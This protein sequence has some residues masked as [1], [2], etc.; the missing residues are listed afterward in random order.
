MEQM[1]KKLKL[2]TISEL[3]K[4]IYCS[5]S[6]LIIGC[7]S[8]Y[9]V[10]FNK[11]LIEA[12]DRENV[13]LSQFETDGQL[14]VGKYS[15]NAL[16]NN[17]RTPIHLDL[18]WVLID[19][20]TA[21]CLTPEQLTLLGFTDEIIEVAQQNLID[22]CYPIEKEKQITTY[23]DKG[24]M[25]LS[26]SAPQ[27]WLKYKDA[28]WTP[29][30]LWDH[31]IAGAFL[32]YNLYASHYA[33]HQ[34]DNSQNISSYGQAGVNLGAWRLRTDYQYDQSF[35]NGKS[36]ANNLDFPRIYLFRPIPEI[37]AKLTIGQYDT[38]SSIFDS[39]HFSG[40]SLKSDE[41][42]LPPDLRG[43][44]PQITGVAQTN[45]KVTVSQNNRII[46]QENV[47][48]GPFA[49][50]NLFN[51]LQGQLDVKV[52]EEDGQVTQWQVASNSIPY[53]TRKGQ[54]RYTTAMGKP[55]S[56]GGDSL[57]QPFF[58]TGEF[59]WG[60]LNN[61]SLYGGSVLTNRDYQSL[62]AGV[63]FN[64]NSLGSLSFDVTRSDAQLHNQDKETGYSY[65]A[66]Y[67]KRFESTGSQLTFAGYRFSDKNFVT[68]NEY[69]NDTN[70]Y[71]NYQNE[72]ESYIV[73]FNQ[74]LESLRLNTYV[75]LA[76]NTY[77][78]ASSNVNYSLSLSRDFDIGPLKNVSTSLT[79]SRINWEED[80]QDQLYL[81]ISIPWGT[82]RTLSYGMQRNQDNKI[83][84]TASW[85]DSSDRNNSWSVSASGD[86]DEFKDMKASLR[87]SYQHNTENGRL[88]LSGTS[89]RDS[90]YSLNASW[91]GSFT[92]TRHGAAFHDYSGSADSRFMIDADG[93]EDIP[94]NNKRAVTN[95][96]G[97]GVIPSV[98]SYIT[99]SLSV[100]TRNLPENVDIENSVITTTLT[101]G[102]IGYAKLDTRKGYQI[103]GV[104]R[105]AD[106]SHPPLGI[107]VKDKTSHKE[108]GLVADGGFV[109]LNGIQD[110]SKLTLRWGDKS[111]FIQPPNSSNLTTGTVIL[112][113]IS[114]N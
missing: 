30:E 19:N 55:T 49:I 9:A 10:E 75:S 94:L 96:Y 108:L 14:P 3:I 56:V 42:M 25:Q 89:Q 11:D 1:Y 105:L 7:A 12:E 81:N 85:Y 109:Y 26:I 95:R 100:D 98:S 86:N 90:Y 82:S 70:H 74:Y 69:I 78:D 67:S 29:P 44:A 64:L 112:P 23:L 5:L 102:A 39:F 93:A 103:M 77:W 43:Y 45:A 110:D 72:K 99:T 34:G 20:Q 4:N 91:N 47:P 6:V 60:W 21:V 63:G 50:T 37:N 22:G 8:A 2:T 111:C 18:Q 80:N 92:A 97:I 65:R 41:N 38:E 76:R 83:S 71:T 66:N 33:P 35:N 17:K 68:M 57:Q 61:V 73:T 101:E 13:N 104:I 87:A 31:G 24:K 54:I 28:N 114:Q 107:S 36:Q 113:C 15:L 40:V 58:W 46:Y 16:I 53:L 79:F 62:A 32:D 84:H 59:S 106:G 51:T 48:P 52:E 27:A 88:Y